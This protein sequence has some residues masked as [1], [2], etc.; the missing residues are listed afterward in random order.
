[1]LATLVDTTARATDRTT[2]HRAVLGS[3]PFKCLFLVKLMVAFK[4]GASSFEFARSCLF[5]QGHDHCHRS[6]LGNSLV[7]NVSCL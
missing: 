7:D 1:M 5:I 6:K 2:M 3:Y 4:E